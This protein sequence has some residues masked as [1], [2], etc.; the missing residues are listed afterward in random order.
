VYCDGRVFANVMLRGKKEYLG[1]NNH[2]IAV[3]SG[4]YPLPDKFFGAPVLAISNA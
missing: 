4:F 1:G 2:L 3:A